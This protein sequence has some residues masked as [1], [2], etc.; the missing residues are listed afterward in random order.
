M[1]LFAISMRHCHGGEEGASDLRSS[2]TRSES[3]QCRATRLLIMLIS[4]SP[5]SLVSAVQG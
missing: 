2:M 3:G 1:A 4:F 5:C